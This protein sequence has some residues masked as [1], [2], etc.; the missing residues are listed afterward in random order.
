M[1]KSNQLFEAMGKIDDDIAANAIEAAR[2]KR[3]KPLTLVI[4]AAAAAIL[5]VIAGAAARND[6]FR[7]TFHG[8]NASERGFTATLTDQQYTIPEELEPLRDSY[9]TIRGFTEMLPSELY[10]KLGLTMLTSE[11]FTETKDV[12]MRR[13]IH[14][15]D[16]HTGDIYHAWE[17]SIRGDEI[18]LEVEYCLHDDNISA[19]VWFKGYYVADNERYIMQ[20]GRFGLADEDADIVTLSDG[21][22]AM[23][24]D[25]S[26]A[27]CLDGVFYMLDFDDYKNESIATIDNMK[28][29]LADL[30]LIDN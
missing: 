15:D 5:T 18:H 28:Q 27:F 21:S 17:P 12:K 29:V 1:T 2:H 14:S 13:A 25:R 10:E 23:V 24:S 20:G 22:L 6:D 9:G 19:N 11:N 30:M 8:D 3:K 7:I 16:Y 4:I 26:A